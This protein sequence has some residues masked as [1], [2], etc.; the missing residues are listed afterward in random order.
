M[1]R[2]IVVGVVCV[3]AACL[4]PPTQREQAE[5][6]DFLA[7]YRSVRTPTV[8]KLCAPLVADQE[9][10]VN[11]ARS[12]LNANAETIARVRASVLAKMSSEDLE[13]SNGRMLRELEDEFAWYSEA[14][15]LE[16]CGEAYNSYTLPA[17]T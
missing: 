2:L 8:V 13:K 7:Y 16:F 5:V 4:P 15:K 12:W 3:L 17:R 1:S 9:G 6:R 10:F 11:A 14:K